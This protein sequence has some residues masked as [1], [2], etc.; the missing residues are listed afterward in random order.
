MDLGVS[1]ISFGKGVASLG[2]DS[3]GVD[4]DGLGFFSAL[5]GGSGVTTF[6]FRQSLLLALTGL[7]H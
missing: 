3:L 4:S 1:V 6:F 7:L 5:D 2:V